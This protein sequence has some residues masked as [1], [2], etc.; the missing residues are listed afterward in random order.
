[1][2]RW[3][4]AHCHFDFPQFDGRRAEVWR[5]AQAAGISRLVIPGV[6]Q[7]DWARVRTVADSFAG[8]DYCLGIHPWYIAEHDERALAELEELVTAAP[9]G[10]VAIGECGLDRV[11]GN[12]AQQQP[13]FEVQ[14][15]LAMAANLPLVIHSVRTHDEVCALLRRKSVSVPVLVHGFAGSYQQAAQLIDLGCLL[16]VGGVITYPRARKTAAALARVPLASLVLETDA[17][18]MPPAGCA[19]GANTPLNIPRIFTALA[20]LRPEPAAEIERQLRA[21]VRRLYRW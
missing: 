1:M 4:D 20:A 3:V 17:P 6:R 18:D 13:W 19:P 12:L 15:D 8:V 16:G 14:V 5:Q 21:N 9:P 7:A 10:L 2:G 11:R